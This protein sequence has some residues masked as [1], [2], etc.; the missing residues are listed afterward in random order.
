MK[1]IQGRRR[2]EYE[3][4]ETI[5]LWQKLRKERREVMKRR[6]IFEK[7]LTGFYE[8]KTETQRRI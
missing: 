1:L 7:E 3:K 8:N 5:Q 6:N 2:A 4:P